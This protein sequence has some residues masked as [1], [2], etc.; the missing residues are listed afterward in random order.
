[1][2]VAKCV[3]VHEIVSFVIGFIV[4]FNFVTKNKRAFSIFCLLFAI[5]KVNVIPVV[6]A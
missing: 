6:Y 1:M 2:Y 5:K 4:N 3:N